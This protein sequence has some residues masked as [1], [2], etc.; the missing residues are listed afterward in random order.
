MAYASRSLSPV[1]QRY[2][3]TVRDALSGDDEHV[4]DFSFTFT[5]ANLT[6]LV[7]TNLWKFSS[8]AVVIPPLIERW[9]APNLQSQDCLPT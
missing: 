8:M 3:Q 5:A 9:P 2:S 4:R 7:I 1:E 6:W